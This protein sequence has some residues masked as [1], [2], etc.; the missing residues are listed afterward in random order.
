[1]EIIWIKLDKVSIT[2]TPP[3]TASDNSWRVKMAMAAREPPKARE[4][5][6]PINTLAGWVLNTKKPRREPIK[7][8][9]KIAI[10][11]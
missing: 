9:Q 3:T 10:S 7:T 5:V 6:S 8:K 11:W 4:P 2:N 1:M